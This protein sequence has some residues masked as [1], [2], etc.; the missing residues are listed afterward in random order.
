[1]LRQKD[2]LGLLDPDWS[3][4]PPVLAGRDLTDPV[5]LTDTV[6]LDTAE[7]R[8][9]ARR[10]A[11]EA[12]V[13]VHNDGLLPLTSPTRVAPARIAM[14]GPNADDP[15]AMFGC[16]SF[17]AHIGSQHPDAGLGI[18]TET[19]VEAL[20]QEFPDSTV[21][22]F[23]GTTVDGGELDGIGEAVEMACGADVVVLTLGDRAGLFG[24]GTSGEGCDAASLRL[25]GAQQ[26][27]LEAVLDTGTPTVVV[28]LA[29][30]PYALGSAPA[31]A[32]AIVQSFFPGEEGAAAL[33]GVLS[34]RVNPSGRLPVGVPAHP[35]AQPGT[36]LAP[37]LARRSDLSTVDPTPAY[38]FGHGLGY[39]TFDWTRP[40]VAADSVGVDGVVRLSLRVTNTGERAGVDVVQFYLHDPV[41]SVVLPVRRLIGYARVDLAAGGSV[42]VDVEIPADLASFTGRHGTRVVEPGEVV[43][44][45][46]RSSADIV[47]RCPV[48]LVGVTRVV[49]HQRR[50]QPTIRIG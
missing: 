46:A 44:E 49:D 5:A 31:S 7:N 2:E 37:P 34:G 23:A 48:H 29:G 39:T 41:A 21:E 35:D 42:T 43:I 36:Y 32:G 47:A 28:L 33:S 13:L 6:G 12:V 22:Y 25:P 11:E 4:V 3:E 14:I 18:R 30:R 38:P 27:L 15:Y 24:R 17:P 40:T 50:L 19:L 10:L 20:R 8:T 16:Y 45:V 1:V 26:D 9:L